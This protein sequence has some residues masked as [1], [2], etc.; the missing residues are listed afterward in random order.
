MFSKLFLVLTFLTFFTRFIKLDWGDGHYFHPDEN[1][2]AVALSRIS[3]Y[4]LD[5]KFYAYGQFPLYLSFFSFRIFNFLIDREA[6]FS[7]TFAQSVTALRFWSATFSV[8][9]V[10]IFYLISR[11]ISTKKYFSLIFVTLLILNP[12][13]IQFSH[14]G[15]TES[16]LIFVLACNIYFGLLILKARGLGL[17][18]LLLISSVVSGMG[19]A[20]KITSIILIGPVIAALL[21]IFF[22]KNNKLLTILLSESFIILTIIFYA[23]LSPFNIISKTDFTSSMSYETSVATGKLKVFYTNQF[24][25]TQPYIFQLTHIFPYVNGLPVFI[26]AFIGIFHFI[27]N[28][29]KPFIHRYKWLI[30]FSTPLVYFIYIGQLYTKWTR[31]MSPIFFIFPFFA[32][33]YLSLIKSNKLRIILVI[34]GIF[35]GLIFA[36]R[37]FQKDIRVVASEW[38]NK[39]IPEKSNIISEG[40]NVVDFPITTKNYNINHFNFYNLDQDPVFPEKLSPLVSE[41][42]YIFIPSRRIFKNQHGPDFPQSD[43]YYRQLFS[44]ISG[45]KIIKVFP[46]QVGLLNPEKAEETWTVFDRPVIR[47]FKKVK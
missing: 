32:S 44:G 11:Q 34:I 40:G 31:F 38:V 17:A 35:P 27:K 15:T 9:S 2:M 5:P 42:D 22:K 28:T 41:A 43:R 10:Y 39:N 6:P 18:K 20:S 25:D 19:L 26:M 4:D 24:I 14:F 3:I 36:S 47:I 12:G 21:F 30:I 7:L 8:F 13:L 29:P 16:I 37:Y 23:C 33:Y 45:F 46:K 1:N